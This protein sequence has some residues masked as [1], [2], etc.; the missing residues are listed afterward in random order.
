MLLFQ[1]ILVYTLLTVLMC[2]Y[3]S[4][5]YG[6]EK[7][8]WQYGWLPIILF[9]LVFGLRY[10]VGIDYNNYSDI[11]EETSSYRSLAKL[12]E[13]ERY[14]PGFSILLYVCHLIH[15]PEYI[16][17]T[18]I[19]F[20]QIVLIYKTFKDEGRVLPYIYL[21][22]ILTG[23]CMYSMMNVLRHEIALFIFLYSLKYIRD[24]KLLKYWLCCLIALC[25]H[26]SAIILFP[27]YF[28]WKIRKPFFNN[29]RLEIIIVFASFVLSFFAQWQNILHMFDNLIVLLGYETYIDIADDMIVNSKIGITRLFN[30][31]INCIIIINS[32]KIKAYFNS[33]LL[34]I[35]YDLF[36]VGVALGYIFLSSM[37]MMRMIVYVNHVQFII[38]AY[39]LCYLHQTR[40]TNVKQFVQY[41]LVAL[42]IFVSY[43]S[44]LHHSMDNT[45]AYV[46]YFQTDMH[47][48]KDH[49][50]AEGLSNKK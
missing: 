35:L 50:R 47:A 13:G 42:F 25:F 3:A 1:T 24:D 39:A 49:L 15:A 45:G 6:K 38:L 2:Y 5:S 48:L 31:L 4:K 29:P 8:A 46:F 16:L 28:V 17:F 27:L 41:A 7:W 32:K 9:T 37:M 20:I 11:Y 34:N 43:S 33:G 18:I 21:S 36:I 12:L 22:M 19:A 14:E 10:G 40:R 23:F 26:F 44:F 30:L